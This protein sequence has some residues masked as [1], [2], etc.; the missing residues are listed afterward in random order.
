MPFFNI[1]KYFSE[2]GGRGGAAATGK[3]CDPSE[4]AFLDAPGSDQDR[5]QARA[6]RA[7][8]RETR[9]R[10]RNEDRATRKD[11]RERDRDEARREREEVRDERAQERKEI[12]QERS[13]NRAERE[14]ERKEARDEVREERD[15]ARG[16]WARKRDESENEDGRDDEG[17]VDDRA[18]ECDA[19]EQRNE[20]R[21]AGDLDE[22]DPADD[23]GS[24]PGC[25][26]SGP[27]GQETQPEADMTC[28]AENML[29]VGTEASEILAGDCGNDELYG[30]I[31]DDKLLGGDGRDYLSGNQGADLLTGGRGADVFA[32][33]GD[34]DREVVTDFAAEEGDTIQFTFYSPDRIE[35]TGETL[36][37]L[38]LQDGADIVFSLPDGDETAILL[39]TDL[40]ELTS[41]LIGVVIYQPADHLLG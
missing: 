21:G 13:E 39:D 24:D 23:A 12:R 3:A 18:E 37:D 8:A 36:I 32:F 31:G 22:G 6:A 33:D 11:S 29:V 19:P 4:T 7:E 40:N 16:D 35:W 25:V 38:A 17:D 2:W 5:A 28:A 10:Q 20:S 1:Y 30:A 27:A 9:D 26:D 15:E 14:R 34:F 41:D